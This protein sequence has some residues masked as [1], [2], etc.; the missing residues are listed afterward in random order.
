MFFATFAK[1][2]NILNYDKKNLC[3]FNLARRNV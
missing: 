3:I 2:V 1:Q